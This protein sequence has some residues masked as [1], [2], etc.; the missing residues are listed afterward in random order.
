MDTVRH[1]QFVEKDES[2]DSMDDEYKLGSR[3]ST[4]HHFESFIPSSHEKHRSFQSHQFDEYF[5]S[6]S[7][8]TFPLAMITAN[9]LCPAVGSA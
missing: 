5:V 4:S 1:S 9:K 3:F 2:R 7:S 6:Q 8:Y